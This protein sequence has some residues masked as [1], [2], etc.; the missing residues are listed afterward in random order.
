MGIKNI[1]PNTGRMLRE[2]GSVVNIADAMY[3]NVDLI[4]TAPQ[5]DAYPTTK[6]R[7][8]VDVWTL[9]DS[10][11]VLGYYLWSGTTWLAL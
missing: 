3:A 10:T 6:L 9:T 11:K 1:E 5:R 8:N 7:K 4:G 2:D